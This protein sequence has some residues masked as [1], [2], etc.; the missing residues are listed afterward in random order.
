MGGSILLK[1][2]IDGMFY[3]FVE[4]VLTSFEASF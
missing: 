3:F 1:N 2:L 4:F